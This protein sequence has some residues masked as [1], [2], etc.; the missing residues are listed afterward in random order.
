[1]RVRD[2]AALT[3]REVLRDFLRDRGFSLR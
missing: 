3:G 2:E 1:L